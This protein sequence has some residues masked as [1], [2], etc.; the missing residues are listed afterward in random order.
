MKNDLI[1]FP[2]VYSKMGKMTCNEYHFISLL[3]FVG[4]KNKDRETIFTST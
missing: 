3:M 2:D 4:S 1:P